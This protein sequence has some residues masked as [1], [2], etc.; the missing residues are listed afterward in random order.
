MFL[1]GK[2]CPCGIGGT[3]EEQDD[4]IRHYKQIQLSVC[5]A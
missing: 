3:E 2:F 5:D 4:D 1:K